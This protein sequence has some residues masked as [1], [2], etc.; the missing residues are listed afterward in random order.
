MELQAWN[1]STL[2][3]KAGGIGES[4]VFSELTRRGQGKAGL[5]GRH[6]VSIQIV[7]EG[8]RNHECP[9]LDTMIRVYDPSTPE[10]QAGASSSRPACAI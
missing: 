2:K 1:P 6:P 4:A 9:E 3:G 8:A 7:D 10:T 5:S